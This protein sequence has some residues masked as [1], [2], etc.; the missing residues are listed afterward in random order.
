[1]VILSVEITKSHKSIKDVKESRS[2]LILNDLIF[3]IGIFASLT[4]WLIYDLASKVLAHY[5][6]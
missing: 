6:H 3:I 1:M 2:S 4:N 5:W